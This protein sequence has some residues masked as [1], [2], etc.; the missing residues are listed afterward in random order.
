SAW[1]G[2]KS[3]LEQ[4]VEKQQHTVKSLE[5]TH[6]AKYELLVKQHDIQRRNLKST[7]EAERKKV[8]MYC[9]RAALKRMTRD[10]KEDA[11]EERRTMG[12]KSDGMDNVFLGNDRQEKDQ[13]QGGSSSDDDSSLD[14]AARKKKKDL[15]QAAAD[16][17]AP[18]LTGV[19]NSEAIVQYD[20]LKTGKIYTEMEEMKARGVGVN[21]AVDDYDEVKSKLGP[22]ADTS[23]SRFNDAFRIARAENTR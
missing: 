16:W 23:G 20:D 7:F 3:R 2:G 17:V 19:N 18:T 22:D 6:E 8:A 13:A 10:I 12:N 14:S 15:K 9:R 4:L 5:D 21:Q 11:D 1:S